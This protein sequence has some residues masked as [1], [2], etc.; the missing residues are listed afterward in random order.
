MTYLALANNM[1]GN[2]NQTQAT[3]VYP[4]NEQH[5]RWKDQAEEMD[6]SLSE[7]VQSM[8]EAGLKKF[9]TTIETDESLQELRRQRNDLKEELDKTRERVS[10]L[11]TQLHKGERA[12]IKSYIEE[13]PGA[14]FGDITQH[15]VQTVPQRVANVLEDLEAV[16]EIREEDERYYP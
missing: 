2:G 10:E 6:M 3:M 16:D 4:S 14:D 9:D 11:E 7:F 8:T 15:V 1:P 5:A 13:N 12:A